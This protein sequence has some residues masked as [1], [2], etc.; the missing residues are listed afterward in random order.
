MPDGKTDVLATGVL[1]HRVYGE[2]VFFHWLTRTSQVIRAAPLRDL[3]GQWKEPNVLP[4]G[5]RLLEAIR[6][7]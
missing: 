4:P 7:N 5:L 3:A 6:V 2:G 1:G